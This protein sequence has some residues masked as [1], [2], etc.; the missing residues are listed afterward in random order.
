MGILDDDRPAK[1]DPNNQSP[2]KD[3]F[4]AKTTSARTVRIPRTSKD[5]L[6]LL[7]SEEREAIYEAARRQVESERKEV[8]K[9]AL[10]QEALVEARQ[11][12]E[13]EQ[14]MLNIKMDLAGHSDKI[15]IDMG[16]GGGGVYH[17]G[18]SYDVPVSVYRTLM[19]IMARG[20]AHEE[21]CGSPNRK[22][23]RKPS[24]I[25]TMNYADPAETGLKKP[26]DLVIR[27]KDAGR[28]ASAIVNV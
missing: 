26:K 5:L 2:P 8:A 16:Q 15:V 4:G 23:Y 22:Q 11:E 18:Y 9:K 28:P 24:Y 14:E 19:E 20:W 12:L 7:S 27:P 3:R 13:P 17:H 1:F 10:M 21:E 25:G 6:D